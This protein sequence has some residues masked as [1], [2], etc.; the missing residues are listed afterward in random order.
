YEAC[1]ARDEAA[2][3][4]AIEGVTVRGLR[5]GLAGLDFPAV[6]L[7]EWRRNGMDAIMDGEVEKVAAQ[8]RSE[9]GWFDMWGTLFSKDKATRIATEA[10]ER[11]YRSD[12]VR[13]G[14]ET[15]ANAIG[16]EVGERMEIA[17]ADAA[18][19]ATQ[20]LV[21]FV[22]PRYGSTIARIVGRDATKDMSGASDKGKAAVSTGSLMMEGAGGIAGA[23]VLLVRRQL[24]NMGARIGQRVV[25]AVLGRVIAVVAGGVGLV[26]I[27]KDVWDF[28]HG[29]IP[30]VANEM[31]SAETKEKVRVEI[32][33]ASYE[34]ISEH[35]QEIGS[36]AADRIIEIWHEFR[37]AHAKVLEIAERSPAFKAFLESIR[38]DRLSR[39]DEMVGI[40]L[41]AEGEAGVVKRLENGTL[42]RAVNQ[43]EPAAFEIA[44]DTK[45]L[46]AALQWADLAPEQLARVVE[47]ELHRKADPKEFTKAALTRILALP[48]RL[49][50]SR[51]AGLKTKARD[52]LMELDDQ[53]LVGLARAFDTGELDTLSRYLTGLDREAGQRVL[54]AV[55]NTPAKM[56]LLSRPSVRDAILS[57]R[58]QSAAIGMM[59]RA[60]G[61]F[62][63]GM[64]VEDLSLVRHGLVSP[65]LI[66]ERYPYALPGLGVLGLVLLLAIWRALFGRRRA[67]TVIVQAPAGSSDKRGAA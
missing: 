14:F 15:L 47:N 62:D 27:A 37:R 32:A 22:G 39:L 5:K 64:F 48:D 54:I 38:P 23:I 28:R 57:S 26:L 2:F 46:D 31:T 9:S 53:R 33:R 25:G 60:D 35:M 59:L 8:L 20:C 12:A 41:L 52:P 34:Q 43:L 63:V 13:K 24:S 65:W 51:L 44:R 6:V 11:V 45:S 21:A 29:V 16:R 10:A 50:I 3:R 19:P 17:S 56:A 66:W 42:N 18:E 58:N 36:K 7:H 4:T 67:A 30:I 40:L 49:A 61:I 55:A 1:Q